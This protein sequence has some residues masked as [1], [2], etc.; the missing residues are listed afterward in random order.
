MMT[1]ATFLRGKCVELWREAISGNLHLFFSEGS[2]KL[3]W[4]LKLGKSVGLP[5]LGKLVGLPKPGTMGSNNPFQPVKTLLQQRTTT[6]VVLNMCHC[7]KFFTC[8]TY[9]IYSSLLPFGVYILYGPH[10]FK[11]EETETQRG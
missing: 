9:Y 3:V 10:L 8:L 2:Q 5:K 11:N 7:A 1:K 4:L 6:Y